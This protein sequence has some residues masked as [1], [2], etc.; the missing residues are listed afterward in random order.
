VR[1]LL[2]DGSPDQGRYPASEVNDGAFPEK[3]V[4]LR[5]GDCC[6][7]RCY[8]IELDILFGVDPFESSQSQGHF[9]FLHIIRGGLLTVE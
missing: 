2:I 4:H 1:R 7:S 5:S 3:P 9:L 6:K 8:S